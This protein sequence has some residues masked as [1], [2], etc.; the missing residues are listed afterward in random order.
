MVDCSDGSDPSNIDISLGEVVTCTFQNIK[1]DAG[2]VTLRKDAQPDSEQDFLIGGVPDGSSGHTLDDDGTV[3]GPPNQVGV[4]V[5]PG[6]YRL[7]EQQAVS[8]W[9]LTSA[10]CSDGSPVYE[11]VVSPDESV[12]CTFV[13]QQV[14][15]GTVGV[16]LDQ[17]PDDINQVVDF[18]TGGGL[19][20]PQEP[21]TSSSGTRPSTRSRATRRSSA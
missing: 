5:N 4:Y 8:G 6:T 18:T 10:T 3:T 1:S 19:N 17:Q 11:V 12:T 20:G 7:F 21:R 14:P 9:A 13:N 2:F 16:V 15:S